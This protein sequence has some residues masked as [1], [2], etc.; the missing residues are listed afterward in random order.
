M[1]PDFPEPAR[2]GAG[3]GNDLIGCE[4]EPDQV[5]GLAVQNSGPAQRSPVRPGRPRL[6]ASPPARAFRMAAFGKAYNNGLLQMKTL[7]SAIAFAVAALVAL[8]ALSA[9]LNAGI[10]NQ[11]RPGIARN[12][13]QNGVGIAG[14]R[15][16]PALAQGTRGRQAKASASAQ[17]RQ[18]AASRPGQK[19]RV[20]K[21]VVARAVKRAVNGTLRGLMLKPPAS[22]NRKRR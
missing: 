18:P 11:A 14:R 13:H 5:D 15:T 19:R 22:A 20:P 12:L 7:T 17:T 16:S 10:R 1:I 3:L 2:S 4:F 9:P 8:P 21:K 6:F